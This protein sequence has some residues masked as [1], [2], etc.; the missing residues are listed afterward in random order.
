MAKLKANILCGVYLSLKEKY[1]ACS[2]RLD[3]IVEYGGPQV[4]IYMDRLD[5]LPV[6]LTDELWRLALRINKKRFSS[7]YIQLREIL[8]LPKSKVE[9]ILEIGPGG[10]GEDF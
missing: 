8:E 3:E 6:R 1:P 4:F 9:S 2:Q 5:G 7:Y 10:G